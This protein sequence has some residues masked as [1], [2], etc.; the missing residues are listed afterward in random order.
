STSAFVTRP[1]RPEPRIAAGSMSCS[2]TSLRTAGPIRCSASR[3]SG[4]RS[5]AGGASLST[6]AV[7]AA[8]RATGSGRGRAGA[9]ASAAA[10]AGCSAASA[11][12]LRAGAAPGSSTAS[13]W[14]AVTVAPSLTRISFKIPSVGAGT[15]R[16]TLSVSRSTRFSSRRTASPAFLCQLTSVASAT[17]S[18]SCGTFTSMLTC[19]P[20]CSSALRQ[21][22]L[23]LSRIRGQCRGDQRFLLANV[24]R[25]DAGRG[26]RGARPSCIEKLM[27]VGQR[28]LQAV[29][30][31][32]PRTLILRLFL[33]PDD[34]LRIRIVLDRARVLLDRERIQL[35]DPDQRDAVELLRAASLR[36]L[37][38]DL[39]AA[40]HDPLHALRIELLDLPDQRLEPSP[41]E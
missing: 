30:D 39:A 17:D 31:L 13:T 5:A 8:S 40:E 24:Q 29:P 16:T 37:V 34:L 33:A 15:S 18:G 14:P 9:A 32:V 12:S 11:A 36:E 41:R 25:V 22:R 4:R 1:S 10:R 35:L 38:V 7:T 27:L 21:R 28:L 20:R 19:R 2:S 6:S 26:R 3:D 23:S